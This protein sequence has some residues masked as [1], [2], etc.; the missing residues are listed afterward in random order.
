MALT[1]RTFFRNCQYLNNITKPVKSGVVSVRNQPLR[2]LTNNS[3]C[4]FNILCR[5]LIDIKH[6]SCI[7]ITNRTYGVQN[8]PN[9]D[10]QGPEEK[11]TGLIQRFKEMYRDYWYVLVPVHMAT[12]AM[13]FGGFYYAVRRLVFIYSYKYQFVLCFSIISSNKSFLTFSGVDVLGLLDSLGVSETL[14]APLRD[15]SAGYFALAFALYKLAT[16]LRYAVTVGK[17]L[18]K[19]W[20]IHTT[21]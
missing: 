11:K 13:W 5:P 15:S 19:S 3:S 9:K 2:F 14:M 16:P 17:L 21:C 18:I 4:H 8:E 20:K 7:S 6:V 10:P 12:S 1:C